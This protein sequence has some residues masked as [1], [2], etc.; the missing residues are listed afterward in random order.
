MKVEELATSTKN[1]SIP[2]PCIL[3]NDVKCPYRESM[4]QYVL[5]QCEVCSHAE[6]F[7]RE[8]GEEDEEEDARFLAESERVNQFARCLFEDCLCDGDVGKLLCFGSN[9]ADGKVW[10]CRRFEVGKLKADSVMREAYLSLVG[11]VIP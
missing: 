1:R 7:D 3:F 8:M 2:L 6:R 5:R 9:L 10:K 11:G 4:K